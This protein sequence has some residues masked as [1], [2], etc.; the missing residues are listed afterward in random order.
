MTQIVK[1]RLV[2]VFNWDTGRR[3]WR[4][5]DQVVFAS[6]WD[7]DPEQAYEKWLRRFRLTQE[8]IASAP[9]WGYST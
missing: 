5:S 8:V 1:P 3:E 2:S 9:Q 6:A 7:P 4:C